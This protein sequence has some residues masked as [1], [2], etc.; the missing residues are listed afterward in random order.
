MGLLISEQLEGKLNEDPMSIQQFLSQ[1]HNSLHKSF[2]TII[3][4]Q[5]LSSMTSLFDEEESKEEDLM[6]IDTPNHHSN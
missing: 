4:N 1:S 5:S 3:Y 2:S 6:Q